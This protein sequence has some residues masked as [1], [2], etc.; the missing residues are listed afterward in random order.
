MIELTIRLNREV[1]GRW[2]AEIDTLP[3]ALSYGDS[4][5]EA[6]DHVMLLALNAMLESEDTIRFK[7]DYSPSTLSP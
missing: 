2:I 1:D 3:G 5:G 4:E 6:I 7:V